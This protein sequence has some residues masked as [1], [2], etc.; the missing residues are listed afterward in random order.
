MKE[1]HDVHG[2]FCLVADLG[3]LTLAWPYKDPVTR[4]RA[5]MYSNTG[6]IGSL[7]HLALNNELQS[8]TTEFQQ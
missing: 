6:L 1:I 7:A 2:R 4:V 5:A 3:I 8:I